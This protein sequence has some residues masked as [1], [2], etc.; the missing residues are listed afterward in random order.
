[1]SIVGATWTLMR[2]SLHQGAACQKGTEPGRGK[3]SFE[4]LAGT[5]KWA[6]S[7]VPSSNVSRE[8]PRGRGGEENAH[9]QPY[10]EQV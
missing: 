10:R 7:L 9:T 2:K 8:S 4:T 3:G 1:M 5:Y 6:A